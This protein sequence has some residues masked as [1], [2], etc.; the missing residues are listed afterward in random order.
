MKT[1][2]LC[3]RME[4]IVGNPAVELG[5]LISVEMMG[6]RNS[7]GQV[8]ALNERQRENNYHKPGGCNN[9]RTT[10]STGICGDV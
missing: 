8:L 5:A 10:C 9:I 6:S 4:W 3:S 2:T 7:G 1:V